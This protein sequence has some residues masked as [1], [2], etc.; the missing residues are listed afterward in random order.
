MLLWFVKKESN[1]NGFAIQ[2][3]IDQVVIKKNNKGGITLLLKP[4]GLCCCRL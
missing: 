4:K 3:E 2:A 1:M